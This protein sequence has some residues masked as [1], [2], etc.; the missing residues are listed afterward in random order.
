MISHMP[1][2]TVQF[3]SLSA[4]G[5]HEHDSPQKAKKETEKIKLQ[6]HTKRQRP[7]RLHKLR[8]IPQPIKLPAVLVH[9]HMS[10]RNPNLILFVQNKLIIKKTVENNHICSKL[11]IQLTDLHNSS[12][13]C[14]RLKLQFRQTVSKK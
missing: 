14:R 10:H 5:V 8:P 12:K 13:P 4:V 11:Q 3:A 2:R 9:L 6:I 7:Y 1:L